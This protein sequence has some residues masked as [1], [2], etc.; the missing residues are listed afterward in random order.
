M[1]GNPYSFNTYYQQEKVFNIDDFYSIKKM[2][3]QFF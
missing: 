2:E 3:L 1:V